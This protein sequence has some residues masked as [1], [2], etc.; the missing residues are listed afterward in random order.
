MQ[1][2]AYSTLNRLINMT[3]KIDAYVDCGMALRLMI[4]AGLELQHL[5]V[6]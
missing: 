1:R 6:E 3:G 4:E 5:Y 2:P